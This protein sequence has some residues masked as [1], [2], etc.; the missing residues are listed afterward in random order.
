MRSG[1]N[2]YFMSIAETVATRSTC[3]RRQIGAIIVRD[4]MILTTGYNGAP[5]GV[6]HCT[7]TG[8]IRNKLNIPS[9]ERHELCKAVH[10][11]QNA[12]IQA[13]RHGISICGGD[14]YVTTFPC[15]ICAK[16]II[17]AG[18]KTVFYTGEYSEG[19]GKDMALEYFNE[20]GIQLEKLNDLGN[21]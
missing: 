18:L 11:E 12:I 1:W 8:C 16:M 2:T 5:R 17:N 9:G 4:R 21:R 20:A 19:Y 10:S 6:A 15:V 13:A 14:M 7:E 3:V